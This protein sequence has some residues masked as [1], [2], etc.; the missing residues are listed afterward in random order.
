V[1]RPPP[2]DWPRVLGDLAF[3]LGDVQEGTTHREPASIG[4]LAA[5]LEVPRSTVRGWTEGSEPRH[6]DGEALLMVW[7]G[8]TGK[9][10]AFAPLAPRRDSD[11]N[12]HGSPAHR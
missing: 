7:S 10:S 1:K 5:F 11:S 9:A 3:L 2:T 12:A 6:N 4:T 8:L